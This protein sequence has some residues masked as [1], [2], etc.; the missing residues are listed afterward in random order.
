MTEDWRLLREGVKGSGKAYSQDR[1]LAFLAEAGRC[2][3][4]AVADGHGSAAHFRSDLGAR[5]ATEEFAACARYLTDRLGET[6]GAPERTD[7]TGAPER[8]AAA[9]G[10]RAPGPALPRLHALARDLPRQ[11]VHG[12]RG[13]VALHEANSP[14]HGR[15]DEP[16]PFDVYGSTLLG[17]VVTPELLVCWQLGDGDITL[18]EADGTVRTPLYTGP[19]LGDE[20]E[21]LCL[22]EAWR[23]ARTHWRPL[24]GG[25]PPAVLL[26]TDGLS[27]SFADHAGFLGFVRGVRERAETEGT[28]LVQGKLADWLGHAATHSGD[29]TTLVAAL[30]VARPGSDSGARPLTRGTTR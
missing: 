1:H 9:G 22:P 5:W 3:V 20:T 29:D 11:L 28:E 2:A 17:A 16:P 10:G 21:S 23:R 4:L 18:V 25:P 27:K 6:A 14:A 30:P 8:A 7:A 26:S 12:W 24:T 19:D 13:R 15:P